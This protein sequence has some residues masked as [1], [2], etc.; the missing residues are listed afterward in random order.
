MKPKIGWSQISREV[1][2]ALST[3]PQPNHTTRKVVPIVVVR[4]SAIPLL[5]AAVVLGRLA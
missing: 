5:R 1:T 4:E 2:V 3:I